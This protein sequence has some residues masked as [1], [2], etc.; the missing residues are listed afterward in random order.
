MPRLY[1]RSVLCF[2][3]NLKNRATEHTALPLMGIFLGKT[4]V[5]RTQAPQPL[6]LLCLQEPRLAYNVNDLRIKKWIK[7]MW[8]LCKMEYYSAMK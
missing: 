5:D 3:K 8:Y 6:L 4:K 7:K 2:L 1:W